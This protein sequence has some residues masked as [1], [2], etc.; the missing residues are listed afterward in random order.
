M[1]LSGWRGALAIVFAAVASGDCAAPHST[2]GT[3][4][5]QQRASRGRVALEEIEQGPLQAQQHDLDGGRLRVSVL[6][7]AGTTI[8]GMIGRTRGHAAYKSFMWRKM[9][10]LSVS[11]NSS[12]SEL[13]GLITRFKDAHTVSED[14]CHPK[15]MEAKH[16]LNQLHQELLNM[17]ELINSTESDVQT[18]E[19]KLQDAE[20]PFREAD[21]E[22][23]KRKEDLAEEKE[24]TQRMLEK[25]RLEMAEMRAIAHPELMNLTNRSASLLADE[26]DLPALQVFPTIDVALG[27][28]QQDARQSRAIP[29]EAEGL[30]EKTKDA[31]NTVLTCLADVRDRSRNKALLATGSSSIAVTRAGDCGVNSSTT[32][33][34]SMAN[35]TVANN[36]A[37]NTT[38]TM[39]NLTAVITTPVLM[40]NR[41][42]RSYSCNKVHDRLGGSIWLHCSNATLSADGRG[43]IKLH[44]TVKCR[45]QKEELEAKYV[46]AYVQLSRLIDENEELYASKYA[47]DVLR[48][49]CKRR[50]SP[51]EEAANK[52]KDQLKTKLQMLQSLR[53]KLE[54]MIASETKLRR[55]VEDLTSSCSQLEKT[56]RGLDSVRAAIRALEACPGLDRAEFHIPSW[57]GEWASFDLKNTDSDQAN[58]AAMAEACQAKF[59]Q[60]VRAADIS[61]IE[62]GFIDGLPRNNTASLFLLGTCPKCAG[63]A[64]SETGLSNV[65]GHSRICWDVGS[66]LNRDS[67]RDDCSKNPKAI[68]CVRDRGDLR[69]SDWNATRNIASG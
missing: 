42:Y 34:M 37:A 38:V 35:L 19:S 56:V 22:C 3:A 14:G 49:D 40:R 68:A 43:C 15:L 65:D 25:L 28:L 60:G 62:G 7:R 32:V 6:Q 39:A 12:N 44:S 67:R 1:I 4:L 69:K 47:E 16:Q 17:A 9:D 13:N 48:E 8:M 5:L 66:P 36:T 63:K 26:N 45:R 29:S 59:G 2:A 52:N 53:P 33:I 24:A 54:D 27:L 30:V 18:L 61:E 21:D 46:K 50:K 20:K 58:D 64:D 11:R 55:H 57:A 31:A 10:D 51:L 41:T 23:K